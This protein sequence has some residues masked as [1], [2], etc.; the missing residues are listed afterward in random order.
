M[1]LKIAVPKVTLSGLVFEDLQSEITLVNG[2]LSLPFAAN[3]YGGRVNGKLQI[4]ENEQK[5]NYLTK[6]CHSLS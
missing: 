2:K 5:I 3:I 1:D 6:Y 4:A